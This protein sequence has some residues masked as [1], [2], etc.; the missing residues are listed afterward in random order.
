MTKALN[1]QHRLNA[2]Q[3]FL[4]VQ[5]DVNNTA[6]FE[7]EVI[8][9]SMA[10][11]AD[12]QNSYN[13]KT[14]EELVSRVASSLNVKFEEVRTHEDIADISK[15]YLQQ[16]EISFGQLSLELEDPNVDALL[17]KRE[18]APNQY[19]AVL[20][21]QKTDAR[22]Y[23]NRTHE[24]SHR[25]AEPPQQGLP[26]YRHRANQK[27]RVERTVD[28]VAAEVGFYEPI[29][30]PL[31][32][33][34]TNSFLS[35]EIIE[36][37]RTKFSPSSSLIAISKAVIKHWPM[38]VFLIEAEFRGRKNRPMDDLA[39]RSFVIDWNSYADSSNVYFF[40]NMRV[41]QPSPIFESYYSNAIN[42][43]QE[44]LIHWETSG[45]SRLPSRNAFTSAR[46]Y[47]KGTLAFISLI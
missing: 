17:F 37:I 4:G 42:D 21:L 19:V 32:N 46:P 44:N 27:N 13:C 24:L 15:K 1:E 12:I 10:K 23:C 30:K 18:N 35:W 26:L 28:L 6:E 29:F 7:K 41:P 31:V 16:N 47:H 43:G 2:I 5:A 25:L 39:L 36:Q 22:A 34:F 14:G 8:A 45:N 40:P 20:N 9:A 11:I 3:D 38:P 33:T